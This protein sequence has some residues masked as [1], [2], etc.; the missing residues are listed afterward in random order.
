MWNAK[1]E[2]KKTTASVL[3][4][5]LFRDKPN[6][7]KSSRFICFALDKHSAFAIKIGMLHIFILPRKLL[8]CYYGGCLS[9]ETVCMVQ[10]WEEEPTHKKKL[11]AK[12]S[13]ISQMVQS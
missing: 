8:N 4:G 3:S 6:M 11:L 9:P 13:M 5:L 2:E 10:I 7:T 12:T 1:K